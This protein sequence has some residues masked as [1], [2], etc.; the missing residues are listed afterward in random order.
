M[1]QKKWS[2]SY[3]YDANFMVTSTA[4]NYLSNE[5]KL[6]SSKEQ[7]YK[8]RI[9]MLEQKQASS[10]ITSITSMVLGKKKQKIS[11]NIFS[12]FQLTSQK[13]VLQMNHIFQFIIL[14]HSSSFRIV[15]EFL[16][17]IA[18]FFFLLYWLMKYLGDSSPIEKFPYEFLYYFEGRNQKALFLPERFQVSI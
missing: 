13:F 10:D 14:K 8:S 12:Y 11:R 3:G 2:S 6:V 5:F 15:I 7:P 9:T 16:S 17:Y 1:I 4:F 18:I